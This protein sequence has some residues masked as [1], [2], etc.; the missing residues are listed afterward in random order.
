MHIG[1]NGSENAPRDLSERC[2]E[3]STGEVEDC[4]QA[5][6]KESLRVWRKIIC[7]QQKRIWILLWNNYQDWMNSAAGPDGIEAN[8]RCRDGAA[9]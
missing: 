4:N 6:D 5:S 9:V 3:G 7:H 1:Y 8:A 2:E